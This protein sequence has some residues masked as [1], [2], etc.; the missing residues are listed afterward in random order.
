MADDGV[1]DLIKAMLIRERILGPDHPDVA[2]VVSNLATAWRERG[3]YAN[4]RPLYVRAVRIFEKVPGRTCPGLIWTLNHLARLALEEGKDAE[5]ESLF[6]RAMRASEETLVA[7]HPQVALGLNGL[8]EVHLK[9]GQEAEAELMTRRAQAIL[10]GQ[11]QPVATARCLD[12]LARIATRRGKF[13]EA[14]ALFKQSLDILYRA[15]PYPHP[16]YFRV[17]DHVAEL[18]RGSGRE[19][20]ARAIESSIRFVQRCGTVRPKGPLPIDWS[21]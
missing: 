4:A 8:A 3:D 18:F 16:E 6:R 7:S 5:A 2:E 14:Q 12:L 10:D 17:C 9:R 20:Q 11:D 15:L 13:A 21:D 1:P 19:V